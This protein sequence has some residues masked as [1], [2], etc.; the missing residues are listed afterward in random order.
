M[1]EGESICRLAVYSRGLLPVSTEPT[2]KTCLKMDSSGC[3]QTAQ[4]KEDTALE[5]FD[6]SLL[7][8]VAISGHLGSCLD[9]LGRK[10]IR[11]EQ[12]MFSRNLVSRG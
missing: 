8:A 12:A 7:G 5:W 2:A 3:E 6:S 10:V 11:E 1:E 4:D 9:S